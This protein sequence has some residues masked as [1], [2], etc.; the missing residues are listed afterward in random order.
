M[1]II[2]NISQ[3]VTMAG[4]AR[5]GKHLS[6]PAIL[7]DAAIAIL[8]DKIL[9]LGNSNELLSRYPLSERFDASGMAVV[10]GFVDPH[11]H[12]VWA[13]DRANEFE[14]RLQGKTYME[15]MAAGGGILATLTATRKASLEELVAQSLERALRAFSYGTTTMEAKTGYGLDLE[16]EFKQLQAILLLNRIG[17]LEVVPTYMGAHAIPQEYDGNAAA[18][19]DW[20]CETA[21]PETKK[22]WLEHA[23]GQELPFVDV[24]CEKGVFELEDTRRILVKAAHLGFP[25]KLHADEFENLGG[26]SLAA[27]LG[28]VSADHLV[29]TSLEDIQNLSQSETVAVSLPGTPF[30]L[31]QSEYTPARA[32]IEADGYLALATDLNPGTTWNESMQFIQ[33]LSCRYLKLTPAE[34]LAASTINSAKAISRDYLL[35]SIEPG[36]QA[37]LLILNVDDYR[38]LSYRYGTNLLAIVVKKGQFYPNLSL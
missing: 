28:A 26:A 1:K 16:N 35:G 2:Y 9:E 19:T 29:K 15:I 36:K 12:L 37:D 14:M 22:W 25:L 33:A 10:P 38:K 34:A 5:R 20:L 7:E 17:P 30:G 32:I 21:L 6:E 13:G 8:D 27:E 11:T 31:A 3:C 18:Y 24:F 4:G 23:P